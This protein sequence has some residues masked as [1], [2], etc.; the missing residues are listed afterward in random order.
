MGRALETQMGIS[1]QI[2]II[3][4]GYPPICSYLAVLLP[5]LIATRGS[6]FV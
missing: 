3:S 5:D 1:N 2:L 4:R 6:A